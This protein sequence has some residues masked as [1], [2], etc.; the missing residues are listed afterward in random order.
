MKITIKKATRD[1]CLLIHDMQIK[2]FAS[3]LEKYQDFEISPGNESVERIYE[4]FDQS[5][6]DYYL[7]LLDEMPVGAIRIIRYDE[8]KICK[9]SPVFVLPEF[10]GKGIAQKVFGLIE[11]QYEKTLIW[12]LDTIKS[13]SGNCH[14]YEKLGYRATGQEEVINDKLT[15]IYYEKVC[16]KSVQV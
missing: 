5:V 2:S 11:M 10:C 15:L 8:G 9:V 4:R 6:T 1:D 12:R 16:S 3:L 14:L 7:I 13:E